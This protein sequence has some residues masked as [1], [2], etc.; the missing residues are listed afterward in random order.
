[1]AQRPL[2]QLTFREKIRD[3]AHRSRELVEHMEQNL[4]PRV[5]EIL[6]KTRP[7][8]PG[9]EDD[10]TDV[11]VRNLVSATLES[12]RYGSQIEEQIEA[13]GK[14]IDDELNGILNLPNV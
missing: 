10:L 14:A 4:V 1:M 8:R 7:R 2:E 12:H 9:H 6:H 5:D 11:S 3:C 13:Y